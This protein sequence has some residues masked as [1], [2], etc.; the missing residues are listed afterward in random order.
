[1]K[2]L[3]TWFGLIPRSSFENQKPVIKIAKSTYPEDQPTE[4]DWINEFRVS[5]LYGKLAVHF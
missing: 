2:E 3:L 5:I 4:Q 1:M